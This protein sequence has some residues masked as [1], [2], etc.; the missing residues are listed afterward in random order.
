MQ[1]LNSRCFRNIS[2]TRSVVPVHHPLL[3][4]RLAGERRQMESKM[5][6]LCA[7]VMKKDVKIR[8]S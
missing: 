4:A 8:D 1:K 2:P 5:P 7:W 6:A 3:A